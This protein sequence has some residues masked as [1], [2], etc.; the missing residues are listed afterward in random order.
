MRLYTV[1]K[2]I[3]TGSTLGLDFLERRRI[4]FILLFGS[5]IMNAI[6]G[7]LCNYYGKVFG[8]HKHVD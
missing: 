1:T 7:I 4:I 6:F 2:T 3:Y 8:G 5:E